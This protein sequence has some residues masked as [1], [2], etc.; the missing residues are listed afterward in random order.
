[1]V[2]E[3]AAAGDVVATEAAASVCTEAVDEAAAVS[4]GVATGVGAEAADVAAA[5]GAAG[6]EAAEVVAAGAEAGSCSREKDMHNGQGEVGGLP[7]GFVIP[8]ESSS[9]G[10]HLTLRGIAK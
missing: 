4:A 8:Y 1:V 7:V 10:L 2:S 9:I 3:A 6:G 5:V